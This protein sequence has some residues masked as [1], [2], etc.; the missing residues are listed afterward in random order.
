MGKREQIELWK[1]EEVRVEDLLEMENRNNEAK[2]FEGEK[3]PIRN[4]NVG[5]TE[6]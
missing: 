3:D 2:N 6:H 5:E 1:I 4:R